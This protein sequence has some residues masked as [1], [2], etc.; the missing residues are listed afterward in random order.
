[1]GRLA[2]L[3]VDVLCPGMAVEAGPHQLAI[4]NPPVAAV[5]GGV[6]GDHA[7]GPRAHTREQRSA[8]VVVPRR[9]ADGEQGDDPGVDEVL[10][11]QGAHVGHRIE[12][13]AGDV[14]QLR[15]R[16][17][18]LAEDAVHP[19][20]TVPV[21]S[22][23]GHQHQRLLSHLRAPPGWF[24]GSLP[25]GGPT[26]SASLHAAICRGRSPARLAMKA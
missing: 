14:G 6:D 2:D 18:R 24:S 10:G 3:Q 13:H 4:L 21:G 11:R 19:S 7:C 1:M 16:D 15:H 5:G 9:L 22:G 8:L 20:R 17:G 23:L 12:R 26:A 25:A